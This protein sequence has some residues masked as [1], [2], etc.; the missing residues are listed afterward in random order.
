MR[1]QT[2]L[3][4]WAEFI[5]AIRGFFQAEGLLEVFTPTLVPAGAFEASID[6]LQVSFEKGSAELHTSPEIEMKRLLAEHRTS[7]F[8]IC[9][10][11]RDDPPTGVHLREFTML[12]YYRVGAD[13]TALMNDIRRLVIRLAGR[14]LEFR[15]V[16]MEEAVR[17][18]TGIELDSA[19]VEDFGK[20]ISLS[21]NDTW[22][23]AFFKLLIEKIEPS[24]DPE[25]PTLLKDYPLPL[26]AL[27]KTNGKITE[28]FE[29]YWK[30]MEICNAC[31]ELG[32]L[33]EL[34]KRYAVESRAR[35]ARGRKPHPHPTVL[36]DALKKGLPPSAGV[37]V[38][39]DRLFWALFGKS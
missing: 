31:T 10:S 5:Q 33:S 9:K 3:Q 34:E 22:E 20:V 18:S 6:C 23:D 21:K 27:A 4:K 16:T 14:E 39:L 19:T 2:D 7:I 24:F 38:G 15:E 11:Y 26:C 35:L 25:V 32:D 17:E 29:L 13:Y 8:Q 12:E 1:V 37:A 28:R 36:A 30:G